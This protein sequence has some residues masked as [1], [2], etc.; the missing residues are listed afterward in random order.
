MTAVSRIYSKRAY[1]NK[2]Q[3][4]SLVKVQLSGSQ[5]FVSR[6]PVL[7]SGEYLIYRVTCVMQY[8]GKATQ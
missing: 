3:H 7:R 5:T 8:H 6:V 1:S 4:R 2:L